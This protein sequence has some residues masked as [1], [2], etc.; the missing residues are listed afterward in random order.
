MHM[1]AVGHETAWRSFDVPVVTA[2]VVHADPV[3]VTSSA[4]PWL[5]TAK[6]V[7]VDPQATASGVPP[8]GTVPVAVDHDEEPPLVVTSTCH[9]FAKL[10]TPAHVEVPRTH[11]L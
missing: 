7:D 3:S 11:E 4:V 1:V 8:P 9:V 10:P 6:H 5:P 2:V